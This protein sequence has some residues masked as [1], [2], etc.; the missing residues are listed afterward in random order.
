MKEEDTQI[1]CQ[2]ENPINEGRR[3][4]LT[5]LAASGGAIAA[6]MV[7]PGKWVKPVVDWGV[8]PVHAQV[9]PTIVL[10]N[11][12]IGPSGGGFDATFFY[13]DGAG[14]VSSSANLFASITPCGELSFSGQPISSI[15]GASILNGTGFMG[16]IGF[17][18]VMINCTLNGT[19]SLC[20][21]LGVGMR[22]SNQLCGNIP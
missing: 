2:E 7:L 21:R 16:V 22:L 3:R 10:S 14:Q 15:P 19:A 20:V 9:S 12:Q 18:F 1:E 8:L 5:M 13:N 17:P 11:L 6:S 4:L